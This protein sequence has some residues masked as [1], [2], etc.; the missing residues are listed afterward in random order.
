MIVK[1][2]LYRVDLDRLTEIHA[3]RDNLKNS[4]P[5]MRSWLRLLLTVASTVTPTTPS[6]QLL[7]G[8]VCNDGICRTYTIDFGDKHLTTAP[9][10]GTWPEVLGMAI[11]IENVDHVGAEEYMDDVLRWLGKEYASCEL[12]KSR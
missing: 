9:I 12:L 6:E 10:T 3:R 7:V 8:I 1:D 5:N 4:N 2:L 11:C